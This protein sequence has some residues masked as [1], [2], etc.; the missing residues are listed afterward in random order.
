MCKKPLIWTD[1]ILI[2]LTDNYTSTS[3]AE[4]AGLLGVSVDGIA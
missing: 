3:N 2:F 1:E 4:L